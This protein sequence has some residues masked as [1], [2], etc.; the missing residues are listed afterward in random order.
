MQGNQGKRRISKIKG[1]KLQGNQEKNREE[2][3][4]DKFTKIIFM[5]KNLISQRDFSKIVR[6]QQNQKSSATKIIQEIFPL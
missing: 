2:N 1:R 6:K 4:K 3:A 5:E